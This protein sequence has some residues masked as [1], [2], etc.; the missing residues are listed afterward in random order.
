MKTPALASGKIE[1]DMG[2]CEGREGSLGSSRESPDLEA[3]APKGGCAHSRSAPSPGPT[4]AW[5]TMP[6]LGLVGSQG[7]Y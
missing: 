5:G 6:H 7:Q 3:E 1:G 4:R 2:A